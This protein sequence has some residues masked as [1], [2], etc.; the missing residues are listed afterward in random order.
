MIVNFFWLRITNNLLNFNAEELVA[1]KFCVL[2]Y[3]R[4][5]LCQPQV[6]VYLAFALNFTDPLDE[7]SKLC[8]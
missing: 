2:V 5:T 1:Q 6:E 8:F 3:Y 7:Y 4:R